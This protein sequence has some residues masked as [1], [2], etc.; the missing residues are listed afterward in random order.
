MYRTSK[1]FKSRYLIIKLYVLS[2]KANKFINY[3]PFSLFKS[4]IPW[5][6]NNLILIL[7]KYYEEKFYHI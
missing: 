6:H 3:N 1:F 2:D 5:K 4:N 7:D